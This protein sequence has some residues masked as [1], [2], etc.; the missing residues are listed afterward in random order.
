MKIDDD[1]K[2]DVLTLG[3]DLLKG[4]D[5]AD[6]IYEDQYEKEPP[7]R[8]AYYTMFHVLSMMADFADI[9]LTHRDIKPSNMF[10]VK[11][12][13]SNDRIRP[14]LIDF[15][16]TFTDTHDSRYKGT[17]KYMPDEML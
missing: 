4:K 13:S 17:K 6:Y 8:M 14:V 12:N 10:V 1:E 11:D 7:L 16:F 15:A 9:D 2:F 3:M 5:L